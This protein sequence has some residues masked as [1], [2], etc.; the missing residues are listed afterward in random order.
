[1][2]DVYGEYGASI[3]GIDWHDYWI[4]G[5]ENYQGCPDLAQNAGHVPQFFPSWMWDSINR[6]NGNVTEADLISDWNS[7]DVHQYPASFK[8]KRPNDTA[9]SLGLFYQNEY[10]HWSSQVYLDS[11]LPTDNSQCWLTPDPQDPTKKKCDHWW[12]WAYD[13]NDVMKDWFRLWYLS[14]E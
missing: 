14:F 6:T 2:S 3:D 5:F 12:H 1:M 4:Y 9:N 10:L 8:F 11:W 7:P 13:P